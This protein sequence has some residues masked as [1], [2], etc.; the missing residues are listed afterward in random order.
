M[1]YA[2]DGV[3]YLILDVFHDLIVF[4]TSNILSQ[5]S[6][7]RA[8]GLFYEDQIDDGHGSGPVR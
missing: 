3:E 2:M 8:C 1:E 7:S 6:E 5:V 4:I